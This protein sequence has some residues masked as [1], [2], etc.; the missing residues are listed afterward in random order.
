MDNA[1]DS[2]KRSFR[3]TVFAIG[4]YGIAAAILY[5]IVQ[6]ADLETLETHLQSLDWLYLLLAFACFTLAQI[7]STL[8]MNAYYHHAGR[9]ISLGYS[10]ILYYVG[11]FYNI[12]LPG[13]I[14]GDGYKV[15]LLKKQADYPV[16]EGIRI[17]LATRTNGLLV[18]LLSIY[19]TFLFIPFP[20][21]LPIRIAALCLLSL[22]TVASYYILSRKLIGEQSQMEMR[23]LPYS[24]MVQGI[25]PAMAAT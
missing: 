16:K 8:R 9:G 18:L 2:N 12:I 11:L 7:A 21:S 4:K 17:Q 3:K 23:A 24:F 6:Q 22:V 19:V 1:A 13:G 14:G 15:Y 5:F 20:L 10:L 25:I